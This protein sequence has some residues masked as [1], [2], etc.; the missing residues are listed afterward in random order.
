MEDGDSKLFDSLVEFIAARSPQTSLEWETDIIN[1]SGIDKDDVSEDNIADHDDNAVMQ[2]YSHLYVHKPAK[3]SGIGS[4]EDII[5]F[6][7]DENDDYV[8]EESYAQVE[9]TSFLGKSLSKSSAGEKRNFEETFSSDRTPK[10]RQPQKS[11]YMSANVGK[12]TSD[13][14]KPKKKKKR[15]KKVRS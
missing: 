12:L 9:I 8:V 15:N 5:L 7:H 1:D 14:M 11:S 10:Q 2:D 3:K 13:V 4:E 6:D